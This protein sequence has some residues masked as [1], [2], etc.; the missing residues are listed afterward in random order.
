MRAPQQ[1]RELTIGELLDEFSARR[2][3]RITASTPAS[4]NCG[5]EAFRTF[6]PETRKSVRLKPFEAASRLRPAHILD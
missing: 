5:D 3:R 2:P 4:D 1:Q 6:V